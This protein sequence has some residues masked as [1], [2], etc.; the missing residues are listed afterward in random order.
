MSYEN[1]YRNLH[2]FFLIFKSLAF[3][4]SQNGIYDDL[5]ILAFGLVRT[6]GADYRQGFSEVNINSPAEI[7]VRDMRRTAN[8][9]V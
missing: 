6:F 4:I 8:E 5:V 3:E 9:E 1:F 7:R 2:F